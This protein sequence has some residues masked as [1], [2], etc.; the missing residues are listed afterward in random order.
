LL[1]IRLSYTQTLNDK[2]KLSEQNEDLIKLIEILNQKVEVFTTTLTIDKGIIDLPVDCGLPNTEVVLDY[3]TCTYKL[4]YGQLYLTNNYISFISFI[5]LSKVVLNLEL[6]E[7]SYINKLSKKFILGYNTPRTAIE[8]G[9]KDDRTFFFHNMSRRKVIVKL[10]YQQAIK[11]G[12][13]IEILREKEKDD[14]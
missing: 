2:N 7:M 11:L 9:L 4:S 1:D 12:I 14:S 5:G 10:L 3:T 8:I 13:N 6:K